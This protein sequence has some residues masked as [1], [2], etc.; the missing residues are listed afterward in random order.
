MPAMA[1]PLAADKLD[2][3]RGWIAEL[4]GARKAAFEDMNA[5]HGLTEHRAYLQPMPDGNF[6]VLVI[7]EGSG[8]DG[9]LANIAQSDHEFDQWFIAAVADLHGMDTSGPPPPM[10][11]RSL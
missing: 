6:L 2:A 7:A 10:A 4:N 3:W 11:S 8:S 5:R 9:F 1:V